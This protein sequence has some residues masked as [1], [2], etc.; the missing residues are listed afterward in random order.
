MGIA[1]YTDDSFFDG[2]K[3]NCLDAL[4]KRVEVLLAETVDIVDIGAVST[5]PAAIDVSEKEEMQKIKEAI[6]AI[7]KHFPYTLL[8][9]DT[10]RASVAEMAINEGAAMINDISGGTFAPEMIPVTGKLKVPYCLMHTSAKPETMHLHTHYDNLIGDMLYFFSEKLQLLKN[11]GVNDIIIDPGFGFG[12]TLE[13]NYHLL[14]NLEAFSTFQ[15]PLLVGVS[16]KSMIYKALNITP[17]QALNGSTVLHTQALMK[18]AH[19]LR[20]HDVKEAKETIALCQKMDIPF[21]LKNKKHS[22]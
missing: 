10:W 4:L 11:A 21:D 6:R 9:V 22:L 13:Q 14:N 1:N 12:K 15:L 20:V 19:I 16:R 3:Y 8:S 17:E 18:G 5:R 2:G 7:L